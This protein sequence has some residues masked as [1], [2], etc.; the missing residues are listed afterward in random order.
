[1]RQRGPKVVIARFESQLAALGLTTIEG[2]KRFDGALVKRHGTGR[3]DIFKIGVS[4]PEGGSRTLYLKRNWQPYKKDG[5]AGL[6][7]RG[8]VWSQSRQEWENSLA[9]QRAGL[10]TAELVAYGEDC[11]LLWE[12]FSFIIA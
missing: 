11:G 6:L 8:A 9:L 4:L 3:R 1:M 12:R 2:V 7:R 5:L 10:L